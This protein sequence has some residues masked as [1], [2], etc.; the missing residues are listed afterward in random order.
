MEVFI[1]TRI[2]GH[3]VHREKIIPVTVI[4]APSYWPHVPGKY[5]LFRY[6]AD[7]DFMRVSTVDTSE[8]PL[9]PIPSAIRLNPTVPHTSR[10]LVIDRGKNSFPLAI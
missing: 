7:V 3:N 4:E 10:W 8:E 5:T 1:E 2:L 6:T 9:D